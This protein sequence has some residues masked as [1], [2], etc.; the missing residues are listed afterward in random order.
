M[1]KEKFLDYFQTLVYAILAEIC[2]SVGAVAYLSC[3]N[4]VVGSIFFTVGLF[5]IF[6]FGFNLYTG[7]LCYV[8]NNNWRYSLKLLAIIIGNFVGGTT[9][10]LVKK[11]FKPKNQQLKMDV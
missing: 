5:T 6:N 11:L 10:E 7:K 2:I 9:V 1:T 4:A 3:E 8:F